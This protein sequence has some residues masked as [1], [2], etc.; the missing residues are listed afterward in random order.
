[1]SRLDDCA[2]ADRPQWPGAGDSGVSGQ[3]SN[4]S[5]SFNVIVE[6]IINYLGAVGGNMSS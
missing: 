3:T 6:I 5:F 4:M 2:P 1:M